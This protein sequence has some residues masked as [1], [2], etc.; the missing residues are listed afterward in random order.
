MKKAEKEQLNTILLQTAG[1]LA[2]YGIGKQLKQDTTPYL[3]LGSLGGFLIAT[4]L[5]NR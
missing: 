4:F 1:G 3:L 2:G 5:V